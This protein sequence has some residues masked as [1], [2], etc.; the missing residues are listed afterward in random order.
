MVRRC[1]GT[2]CTQ[3]G[4]TQRQLLSPAPDALAA[5]ILWWSARSTAVRAR[6]A[7]RGRGQTHGGRERVIPIP[8]GLAERCLT[9]RMS[10]TLFSELPGEIVRVRR[11]LDGRNAETR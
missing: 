6:R 9:L 8:E 4:L 1:R 3:F 10:T 2:G 11:A 5:S 7:A